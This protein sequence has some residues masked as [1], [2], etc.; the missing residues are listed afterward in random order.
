MGRGIPPEDHQVLKI[1][2][3]GRDGV[4]F[5]GETVEQVLA[6]VM[7]GV[8]EPIRAGLDR[9][10]TRGFTRQEDHEAALAA[11][12]TWD[13]ERQEKGSNDF[14]FGKRIGSL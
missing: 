5:R 13:R 2:R 1:L 11:F 8:R 12:K 14:W 3:E 10:R 9:A 7:E 4:E 6:R